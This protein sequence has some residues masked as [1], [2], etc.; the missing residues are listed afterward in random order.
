[1][2]PTDPAPMAMDPSAD[3]RPGDEHAA[4]LAAAA[5][6]ALAGNLEKGGAKLEQQHKLFVRDRLALLLDEGSFIEDALLANA[7]A[8]DL[9]VTTPSAGRS[10]RRLVTSAVCA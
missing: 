10:V 9:P 1:M 4:M 8:G 2:P 6:R 7:V 5:T 3:A